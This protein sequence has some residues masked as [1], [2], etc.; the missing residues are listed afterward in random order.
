[1]QEVLINLCVALH[2]EYVA[3]TGKVR[4]HKPVIAFLP[5]TAATSCRAQ[6]DQDFLHSHR[7]KQ[8]P[9]PA[10]PS[11]VRSGVAVILKSMHRDRGMPQERTKDLACFC[12]RSCKDQPPCPGPT[13]DRP[14]RVP[15]LL[16]WLLPAR[17]AACLVLCEASV[18][19][20][21]CCTA[22]SSIY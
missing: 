12:A 4:I 18:H 5:S 11:S 7:L 16:R 3:Y 22:F 20:H 14:G 9:V 17:Q 21:R 1:M 10:A 8:Y 19:H 15:S 13:T 2:E 6:I